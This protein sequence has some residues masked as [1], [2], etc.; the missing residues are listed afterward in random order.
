MAKPLNPTEG[1]LAVLTSYMVGQIQE[2]GG[3]PIKTQLVKLLYLLDLDFYKRY[4][5]TVTQLAWEY[6]HHGPYAAKVDRILAKLPDIDESGFTSRAGR[7]GY[8]YT[9]RSDSGLERTEHQLVELFGQ[10]VKH[11]VDRVLDRWALEDLWVLLDHVYFET[12]PMENA[13]RGQTLDFSGV[14][15]EEPSA[16]IL[17]KAGIAKNRLTEFRQRL[18]DCRTKRET[19]RVQTP[20]TYDSIYFESLALMDEDER[21]PSYVSQRQLLSGPQE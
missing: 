3:R 1:E 2:R 16:P 17:P 12:E 8:A 19:V 15:P 4:S 14:L 10:S 13:H 7:K 21:L 18:S 20:A 11:V 5:R 9:F 6:Y